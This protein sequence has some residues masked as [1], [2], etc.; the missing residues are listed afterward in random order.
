[1]QYDFTPIPTN[2]FW[3]VTEQTILPFTATLSVM[4]TDYKYDLESWDLT[5]VLES[6]YSSSAQREGQINFT[7]DL[8][9]VCWDLPYT[10]FSVQDPTN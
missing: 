5:V 4:T 7:L 9:D 6:T 8:K 2:I 1:M 10:S 3:S